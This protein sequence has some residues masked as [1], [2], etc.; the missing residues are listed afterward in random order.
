MNRIIPF[1]FCAV[2]L[3]A[4][5]ETRVPYEL[6]EFDY[7]RKVDTND[8]PIESQEKK[9]YETDDGITVDNLFDAARLNQFQELGRHHYEIGI[10]A[11]NEPINSSPWYAF[12]LYGAAE[13]TA[14][15]IDLE[16]GENKH[17]YWP[18]ISSDGENWNILDSTRFELL[19]DSTRARLN[20]EISGDTTWIA[21]Q[22][23]IDTKDMREWATRQAQSADATLSTVGKSRQNRDLLLL[24]ITKGTPDEKEII[25]VVSRQHPPEV[26]GNLSM[27][28]FVEEMLTGSALSEDFLQR[29]RVLVYPMLNPDGV[30][31]GHWRHNLG[32]VDLNRDWAHYRQP[33]IRQICQ[34]I[35]DQANSA[36]TDVLL[37]LD[38]HSTWSDIYYTVHDSIP[39]RMP[40]FPAEWIGAI[41][42]KMAGFEARVSPSGT[43]SPVSKNWFANQF[44]AVGITYEIGDNTPRDIITRKSQVSAQEMMR[45]L[46]ER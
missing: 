7:T 12:R 4:C 14:V 17:R 35:I 37:G 10:T 11:E 5:E 43:V 26:T 24:D 22:E 15:T 39:T 41:E 3:F 30:D 25:V 1:L 33:E 44:D 8:H 31:L 2:F 32:G 38:F 6:T 21:A 19:G 42:A 36:Q 13:K 9:K 23:I 34:D 46:L 27:M 29:Y 16:Y 20:I 40:G 28:A 18:K 45:I